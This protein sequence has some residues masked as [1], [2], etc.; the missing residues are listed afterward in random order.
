LAAISER[1]L[2]TKKL[3]TEANN[4]ARR[5]ARE[6]RLP[7]PDAITYNR[8][9]FK[10]EQ[11]PDDA[12][13]DEILAGAKSATASFQSVDVTARGR[14]KPV[15][16]ELTISL[17]DS[18][19]Q[20]IGRDMG[21]QWFGQQRRGEASVDHG[22]SD[23]AVVLEEQDLIEPGEAA[24]YDQAAVRVT[25]ES[26]Q[27]T[28]IATDSLRDAFTYP[29]SIGTPPPAYFYEKVAPRVRAVALQWALPM[30]RIMREEIEEWEQI[31]SA[32]NH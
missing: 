27:T 31:D 24:R 23:L 7:L 20:R 25:S 3:A 15:L 2:R 13:L 14:R 11:T 8:L 28:K 4:A 9:L 22:V 17:R 18:V 21:R 6:A 12:Y 19:G 10:A 5:A 30:A 1:D 29:V 32:N 16:R 26:G